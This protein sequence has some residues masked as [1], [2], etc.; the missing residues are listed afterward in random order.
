MIGREPDDELKLQVMS[1]VMAVN[2]ASIL[3]LLDR[4]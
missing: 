4:D 2:L 3:D 1:G